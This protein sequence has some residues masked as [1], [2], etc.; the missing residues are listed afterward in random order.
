MKKL[1]HQPFKLVLLFPMLLLIMISSC[2]KDK[3]E[4]I[5][6]PLQVNSYYPNS[7][8]AGTLVTIEGNGFNSESGNN[9]VEF[10]G[11]KGFVMSAEADKMVVRAPEGGKSG[12][13]QISNGVKSLEV[14]TYTYQ[15]LT[16]KR[17]DPANGP[18]GSHI[19]IYGEGFS[20]MSNPAQVTINGKKAL[21]G[22]A[23]DTLLVVEIPI[24]VGSGPI[25][26]QVDGMKARGQDFTFQSITAIKP[27]SGGKGTKVRITGAGFESLA[28]DNI[29]DFNGKRARVLEITAGSLLVEAP[30]GVETGPM[31]V[32]INGQ[33][34]TG[35]VFTRVPFPDIAQVSPLSG[36]SGLVMTIKGTN[37]SGVLD[38]NKVLINGVEVP[39][40][41]ASS[42]ELKLTLPGGTGSG[43]VV[44]VV[45]DQKTDGPQFKDQ[46][47]GIL[48]ISPDNG[49]AGTTVTITGSGFDINAANNKVTF[50]GLPAQVTA[51][52]GNRL[53]VVAPAQLTTGTISISVDGLQAQAPRE[54]RR[55]G[56]ITIAT[57]LTVNGL[58]TDAQGN[59]FVLEGQKRQVLKINREGKST[60]FASNISGVGMVIDK[61]QNL[62]VSGRDGGIIYKITPSGTV[63]NF[64]SN[65]GPVGKMAI[66]ADNSLIVAVGSSGL[67]RISPDGKIEGVFPV[68]PIYDLLGPFAMN[69]QGG[70]YYVNNIEYPNINYNPIISREE[71]SD[72]FGDGEFGAYQDGIGRNAK[73]SGSF[74][75]LVWDGKESILVV[76]SHYIRSINIATREVST[77]LKLGMGNRDGSLR[78]AQLNSLNELAID[79]GGTIYVSQHNGSI[80]K[81][82]FR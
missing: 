62:F 68:S 65:V 16:I 33:R 59:L 48:D 38:E 81:I 51:A 6:L 35:P 78:D 67:F 1:P 23:N 82:F 31:A 29:V 41:A 53:T 73:F 72:G 47:L 25:E 66:K 21:V 49:L 58:I 24:E 20:S 5:E 26:V 37:F 30:D 11:V 74:G 13:I 2:K 69:G 52:T 71:Y 55:A 28:E 76:D 4:H 64:A 40:T 8:K 36:P 14:G 3:A 39:L 70:I 57:G 32:T 12:N 10:G 17:I 77:F 46:Q 34:A 15:S 75:A 27:L 45:N 50:N 42:E 54:F 80:R 44:V 19:R 61:Q 18:A 22:S 9:T 56:I 43:K 63:S 60:V 79:P 7:G